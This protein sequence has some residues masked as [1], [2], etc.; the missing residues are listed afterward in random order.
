MKSETRLSNF[1]IRA[2]F[3]FGILTMFAVPCLAQEKTITAQ[4]DSIEREI[5]SDLQK[6]QQDVKIFLDKIEILGRVEKPQTVFIVPGSDTEIGDIQID[7]SF[8]EEI[9]RPIEKE[10]LE[11]KIRM[12]R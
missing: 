11:R 7:R 4:Q 5:A 1:I 9:F 8:F 2:I 6:K 3:A 10:A 12:K